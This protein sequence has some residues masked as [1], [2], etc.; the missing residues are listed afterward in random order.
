[1]SNVGVA[2]LDAKIFAGMMRSGLADDAAYTEGT[3]SPMPCRVIVK[4]DTQIIG[5]YGQV[6]GERTTVSFLRAEVPT[7]KR[8]ATVTV[9]TDSWTLESKQH[10]DE[11]VSEWIVNG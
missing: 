2:D 5:E 4:R 1:M 3:G 7:P 10:E 6:V 9:G 11:S 8:S